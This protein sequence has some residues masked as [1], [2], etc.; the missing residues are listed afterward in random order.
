MKTTHQNFGD[1]AKA[2]LRGKFFLAINIY[3][4]KNKRSQTHNLTLHL[5]EG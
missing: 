2:A 1:V 4:K 3:I 5:K